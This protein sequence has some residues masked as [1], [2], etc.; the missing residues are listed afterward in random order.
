MQICKTCGI[1]VIGTA[2]SEEGMRLLNKLGVDKTYN[3]R[4]AG[5]I[6]EIKSNEKNIDIILEMLANVNLQADLEMV[7]TGGRVVVSIR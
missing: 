4:E 6:D 3:H 7:V 2:G 1:H 5:Y